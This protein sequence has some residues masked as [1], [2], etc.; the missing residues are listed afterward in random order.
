MRLFIST[1]GKGERLYPL[2]KDIPNPLVN[3]AGKPI[4]HHLVDWA[5]GQGIS[6]IVMMNGHM[7]EKIVEYFG[8]GNNFGIP[9]IHST[10]PFPLGSG[11]PLKLAGRHINGLCAYIS[12]D[13]ICD[14]NL[15]SMESFHH[16]KKAH[17]TALV[18]PS[19]HPEDS[20]ILKL[21]EEG[22]VV[23]FFSK[24]EE[25]KDAGILGNAGLC[26]F[27]PIILSL[28]DR[29]VFNFENYLF[30]KILNNYLRFFGYQT[31]DFIH[32]T[33]TIERLNKCEEYIKEVSKKVLT[34]N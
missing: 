16:L 11:G 28:M 3:I 12:G 15:K 34:L 26:I 31:E 21:D 30:P 17:I 27:E 2:T 24:K 8:Q 33:G 13:L 29:E 18:H 14:V 19:S 22:R 7:A 4:L 25:H 10:E 20:D 1:G 9:I 6:D 32:D 5:K 23:K